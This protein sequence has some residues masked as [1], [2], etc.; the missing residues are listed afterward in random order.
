MLN[1]LIGA[2]VLIKSFNVLGINNFALNNVENS[3]LT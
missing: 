3:E 2:N 1:T